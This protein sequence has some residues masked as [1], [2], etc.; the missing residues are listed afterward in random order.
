MAKSNTKNP[1]AADGQD[2]HAGRQ[3]SAT[4]QGDHGEEYARLEDFPDD[5][6]TRRRANPGLHLHPSLRFAFIIRLHFPRPNWKERI[7]ISAGALWPV[8]ALFG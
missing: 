5:T 8:Q 6:Q 3:L 7:D 4:V 1:I 2:A